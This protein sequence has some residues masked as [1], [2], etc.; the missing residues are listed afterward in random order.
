MHPMIWTMSMTTAAIVTMASPVMAADP[1]PTDPALVTG[2]LDNGLKYVVRKHAN[3]PGRVSV[4]LHVSSGSLNETDRQRGIAHF[5]EHMAFNGSKNFPPGSV[6]PFFQEQGL[7]FGQDQ[8]AF[9]SFDQTTYQLALADNTP[10]NLRKAMT[11]M[12]D[13]AGEL[14][15]QPKEIESERQIILEERRARSGPQQRVQDYML[16]RIAPGSTFGERLPIGTE[17]T[18]KG[19]T[20]QDFQDYY[21]QWYVKSNMT[22][23][24]VGDI[25]PAVAVGQIKELFGGGEKK[26]KPQDRPTGV[27]ATGEDRAVIA[28]DPE[29]TSASVAMMRVEPAPAPTTTYEQARRELVEFAGSSIFNRRAARAVEQGTAKY[30][31]ASARASDMAGVMRQVQVGAS[32]KPENWRA[33]LGDVASE[34]QR[35][36]KFGFTQQE[37]DDVRAD[38]IASAEVSAQ[39]EGTQPARALLQQYNGHIADG[40]PIMSAAQRLEMLKKLLPTITAEEVSAKFREVF[41]PQTLVFTLQLP[42]NVEAPSESELIKAGREALAASVEKGTEQARAT[43]LLKEMPKGGKVTSTDTHSSSQVNSAWLDNGVRVHHRFMDI[44]KG[45]ATITI[46][47]AGG[48]V[49]ETADNRGITTAAGLA[50]AKPATRTLNSTQVREFMTGKKARVRGGGGNDA[51]QISVSG[52][53][54][55]LDEGLQLAYAMLTEPRLE[56]A[57]F[58]QWRQLMTQMIAGRKTQAQG[59]MSEMMYESLSAPGEMRMRPVTQQQVDKVTL[60]AAQ[61]WLDRA[62]AKAPI[63]VSVVGDIPAEQAMA[64]VTKYL[65]SLP[66]REKIGPDTLKAQ[67][68]MVR[69]KGKMEV[70]RDVATKTD[71]AVVADGFFG[72]EARNI[73]DVR[74]MRMASRILSTRMVTIVRE[75]KQLVYSIGAQSQPNQV[76]PQMGMFIAESSTDPAKASALSATLTEMFTDFARSGPTDEEIVVAKKQIANE[77][78]EQFKDPRSWNGRLAGLDYRGL[79]LDDTMAAPEAYQKITREQVRDAFARYFKDDAKF[80]FVV[81]PVAGAEGAKPAADAMG[82]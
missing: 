16:P 8:N 6:V 2:E 36:L 49:E 30:L 23:I 77:L 50:W 68:A 74:L 14:L 5:L 39:R 63:E 27:K 1:L 71:K 81:M 32:G 73:T 7:R 72:P 51:M 25:D 41:N 66:A 75:Q 44:N 67:R 45:E 58:G 3:P 54:D 48:E 13:V 70:S 78:E 82:Q 20:Q 59:V 17:E 55:S 38:L 40:E 56:E 33:V 26:G 18:I 24:V 12:S 65:G 43:S 69:G 46:T 60:A 62:I 76:Y 29:L 35:A 31:G 47:L 42:S 28:T 34:W 19:V 57:T 15:L 21:K 64:L 80:R 61:A 4:W 79:N 37:L 10:E 53:A 11:F 52:P 9:T 22:V